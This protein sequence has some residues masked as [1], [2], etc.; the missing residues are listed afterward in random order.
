[1]GNIKNLVLGDVE[2]YM[3]LNL[4]LVLSN[5]LLLKACES[6]QNLTNNPVPAEGSKIRAP[7][8]SKPEY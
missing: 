7:R 3:M 4:A 1:M 6:S 2:S 5:F 8:S